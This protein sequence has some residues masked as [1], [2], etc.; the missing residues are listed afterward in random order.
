MIL[1]QGNE[2]SYSITCNNN[3]CKNALVIVESAVNVRRTASKCNTCSSFIVEIKRLGMTSLNCCVFC[4]PEFAQK[5]H[6]LYTSASIRGGDSEDSFPPMQRRPNNVPLQMRK[7]NINAKVLGV[8]RHLPPI[9]NN[10]F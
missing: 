8:K 5:I 6:P 3:K 1:N 2:G 4:T 9:P 10:Q 7:K